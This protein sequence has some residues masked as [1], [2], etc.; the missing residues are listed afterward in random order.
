MTRIGTRNRPQR[1][2]PLPIRYELNG[3]KELLTELAMM[4]DRDK[5]KPPHTKRI[6][7]MTNTVTVY[8]KPNCVQC[9]ATFKAL[10][11]AGIPHTK[12]DVT[13]NA[14]ALE[15]VT[16]LGYLQAPVVV[17]GDDHW[18]GFS[19]DRIKKLA[20]TNAEAVPA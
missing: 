1:G 10:D 11:K 9:N 7:A 8:T 16:S 6:K 18:S 20:A 17:A 19:P 5:S 15:Y 3:R 14:E 2:L 13:E 12:V 4:Y